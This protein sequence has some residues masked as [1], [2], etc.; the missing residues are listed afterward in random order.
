MKSHEVIDESENPS[1]VSEQ[2]Q[3]EDYGKTTPLITLNVKVTD[4]DL[5]TIEV[6]PNNST[7]LT[8]KELVLTT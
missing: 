1:F 3:T 8:L 7:G 6:D 4:S 5:R 2:E